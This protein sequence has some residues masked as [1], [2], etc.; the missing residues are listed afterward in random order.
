MLFWVRQHCHALFCSLTCLLQHYA[1]SVP[2]C[3]SVDEGFFSICHGYC[4]K[5]LDFAVMSRA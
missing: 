1:V 5:E 4:C 2:L 3:R